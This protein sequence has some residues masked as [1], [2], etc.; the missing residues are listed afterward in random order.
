MEFQRV[1]N[2]VGGSFSENLGRIEVR[3]GSRVLAEQFYSVLGKARSVYELD[4]GL[5]W[6][7]T[8]SDL[9]ALEKTLR[10]SR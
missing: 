1:L 9:E 3:L 7:C 6:A 4:I 5:D 10:I 8:T 2:S